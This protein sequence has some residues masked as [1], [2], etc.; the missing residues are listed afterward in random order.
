VGVRRVFRWFLAAAFGAAF[1]AVPPAPAAD[2]RI[3]RKREFVQRVEAAIDRGA[4]WLKG[5]QGPGGA[6]REYGHY[7]GAMTALAY[8][9]LRVC[10]LSRDDP[11]AGQAFGAMRQSYDAARRRNDLRTYTLGVMCMALAEHG[12]P[13]T[14]P[15]RPREPLSRLSESDAVW[16]KEM[17]K[18]LEDWQD[19]HGRWSYPSPRD[20]SYDNSNTQYALLGLKSASRAGAKVRQQT[21]MRSLRHFLDSQEDDGP[22]VPRFEPGE[23]GR[24]SARA[25]DRARGWGYVDGMSAYGSMTAGGAGSVVI[26]RSELLGK[27]DY[28]PGLDAKAEQSAR[29][30]IAWLGSNFAVDTNPS[31]AP[32]KGRANFA[33]MA[34]PTWHYYYLYGLERAGVLGAVEWM[35]DHDWYGEGAEFLLGEQQPSG[36]WSQVNGA[37][38]GAIPMARPDASDTETMLATCFALLFLKKGTLPVARGALTKE[39]DDS[40]INFTAAAALSPQDFEDFLDLVLSRWRRAADPAAKERL[41]AAATAVGPRIVVPLID[42]LASTK[43]TERAAAFALLRRATG[44]D[45]GYDPSAGPEA[46]EVS[47]ACWQSWWLASAK[48]VRFDSDLGRLVSSTPRK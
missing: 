34:G 38:L 35:G 33:N 18:S 23:K 10:G 25:V 30:G 9:T 8:Y 31:G 27:P 39:P 22:Q 12:D 37:R 48:S 36:A 3:E 5:A 2:L 41:F 19:D 15:E 32:Q 45:H 43:D 7:P 28:G 14:A 6:W 11:A 4:A 44:L 29:D 20:G 42:R 46:R 16:M 40:D 47:L 1:F 13:Y 21:W 17:V 26:C 24:T